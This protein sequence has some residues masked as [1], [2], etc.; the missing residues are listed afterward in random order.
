MF[1]HVTIRASHREESERFYETVLATLDVEQTHA[2]ADYAEWDDFS[3]AAA[4]GESPVTRR[5]HIGFV[6]PSREHVDDFWRIGTA[7]GYRSDGEPGPRPQYRED[8]Y[9]SFLLDP[10]GSSVE[11]VH[12]GGMRGSGVD[13]LWLRVADVAASKR[14]YE[15]IAPHAGIRLKHDS[16]ERAQF[17]GESASFSVVAGEPTENVHMAFPANE[18]GTVDAFHAAALAAGYRDH[19]APGERPVYHPGYYGAYVLDPDGNN[20][21]VVNHNR[22]ST[23]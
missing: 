5:L 20:V 12:H 7:A 14:F 22:G 1:D 15:T 11:A 3:L 21:E 13:H 8:Y 19:G 6:A 23:S 16:P 4:S 2:G 18:N 9:G 10:D 17:V